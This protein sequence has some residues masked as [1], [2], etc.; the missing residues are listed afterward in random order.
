MTRGRE[1][2]E[3]LQLLHLH[4]VGVVVLAEEDLDVLAEQVRNLLDDQS[5]VAQRHVAQL[6][7]VH[8]RQRHQRARHL[9]Q[10]RATQLLVTVLH[11]QQNHLH[12]TM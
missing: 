4:V 7:R 2:D 5:Q 12:R 11:V 6:R 8:R 3:Q 9:V 10:R 1:R